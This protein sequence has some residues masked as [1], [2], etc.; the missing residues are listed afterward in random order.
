[1]TENK[2]RFYGSWSF[3]NFLFAGKIFC[4]IVMWEYWSFSSAEELS[5]DGLFP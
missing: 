2:K 4:D 5:G 1:M 3:V